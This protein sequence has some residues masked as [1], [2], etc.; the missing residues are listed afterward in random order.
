MSLT[1]YTDDHP[2]LL[3]ECFPV[4]D[5]KS[6]NILAM[7]MF[8]TMY[9]EGGIGLAANQ[10]GYLLRMFVMD[11][12]GFRNQSRRHTLIN[13]EIIEHS[14]NYFVHKE[15]CLSYK[16]T[17]YKKKRFDWVKVEYTNH[18]GVRKVRKF[19]GI[20]SVIVQHELDHLD[21]IKFTGEEI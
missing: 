6:A 14:N 9:D 7:D 20:E 19:K 18:L 13:P 4:T 10:V 16:N 2:Y 15:G 17:Y 3:S 5:L 1:L 8:M 21:G 12:S 11:S